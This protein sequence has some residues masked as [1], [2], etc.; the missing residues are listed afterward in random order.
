MCMHRA[1]VCDVEKQAPQYYFSPTKQRAILFTVLLLLLI[2]DSHFHVL[3]S[4]LLNI[5]STC[6]ML[7][8]VHTGWRKDLYA[9]LFHLISSID[10]VK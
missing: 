3:P 10:T 2:R 7:I 4:F 1:G 6:Y 9:Y 5:H 8:A